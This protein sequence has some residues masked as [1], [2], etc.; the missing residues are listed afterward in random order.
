MHP[1]GY[2]KRKQ[3]S[4]NKIYYASWGTNKATVNDA[5]TLDSEQRAGDNY[6]PGYHE[7]AFIGYVQVIKPRGEL[8]EVICRKRKQGGQNYGEKIGGYIWDCHLAPSE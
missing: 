3:G 8:G 1:L 2:G 5:E 4:V 7:T 6:G